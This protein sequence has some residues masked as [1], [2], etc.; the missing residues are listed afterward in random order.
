MRFLFFF[1]TFFC[2]HV[3]SAQVVV[4]GA[5]F[6]K[7][8][9]SALAG[10]GVVLLKA[11]DSTFIKGVAT[12]E[13]GKFAI[14]VT[15][16]K[17]LLK[18][19][20]LSYKTQ[21]SALNVKSENIV[22]PNILMVEDAKELKSIT[23]EKTAVRAVQKDDT[24]EYNSAAFKTNKDASTEDL[25]QKMPGITVENGTVKAKGEDVKK[26]LVDG[27]PFFGD[28]PSAALKN[29]PAE[30]VDKIQVYD[31]Q[32]DQSRFT[33]FN[34]GN[35][36]R[37]INI[38]T[39]PNMNNGVFGKIYAGYGYLNSSRYSAG[40]TV[41]WFNGNRRISVLAMS[42]NINQQNF[43]MD[44][45]MGLAGGSGGGRMRGGRMYP[46]M[47][48]NS[49]A[50]NFMV[51][52]QGGITTSQAIGINYSDQWSNKVKVTGSYFFNLT[53]NKNSSE[54]NRQY[55]A[56]GNS[57]TDYNENS[58]S[59]TR[60]MN[61]RLNFRFEYAIDSNNSLFVTPKLSIQQYN[62]KSNL[63]G[64]NSLKDGNAIS[65]LFSNYNT[66]NLGYN[67]S[68]DI[69]FQ[70]K[71]VKVGRTFSVGITGNLNNSDGDAA[72]I[73]KNN[74][75]IIQDSTELNQKTDNSTR[76]YS[77]SANFAYTEPINDLSMMQFT[78]SPSY[79]WS[80]RDKNT[81]DKD[82]LSENYDQ[83]NFQLSNNYENTYMTQKVGF[84]YRLKSKTD[85]INFS[86]GA[87][88]QYALLT[89]K[90]LFPTEGDVKKSFNNLLPNA[91]FKYN[92]SKQG[93][94]RI[95]YNASTSPPSI[96]QLQN[97]IDN[98]NP[99]LISTGNPNLKQNYQHSV[100]VRFNNTNPNNMRM[101]FGYTSFS[102]TQNYIGNSTIIALRDTLL[103]N[104]VVLNAG[105]QL[106]KPVNLSN[107]L[108]LRSFF[109]YGLPVKAI[110]SN[111]NFHAGVT[112]SRT[113]SLINGIANI[114]NTMSAMGGFVLGSNISEKIDFTIR[115][116]GNYNVVKNSL[117][118]QQNNNYYSHNANASFN[119]NFW[120][121]FVFNTSLDNTVYAGVSQGFNQN[122]FLWNAALAYKFLKDRSLEIK[123]SVFDILGQNSSV[124]R[125]VN[126]T[127]LEDVRTQVLQRYYLITITYNLKYFKK[128]KPM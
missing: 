95:N 122:F 21:L 82:T 30:A 99:L 79:T 38:I 25:I 127:Y 101:F 5:I 105:S 7:G 49:P 6:D 117:R 59:T 26:V 19:T 67:S 121:G 115:Y 22:L 109:G 4:S 53:D 41:N 69:L 118:Q 48:R 64:V 103:Q 86:I 123:G 57:T 107:S 47:L 124:S 8:D 87:E 104:N 72:L 42:N 18:Y 36:Q 46:G 78:Y 9:N 74:F 17:Y 2:A 88:M 3:L 113:P 93:N 31:Q 40:A 71:F 96:S 55:F 77:G 75:S 54:T 70:H 63:Y 94:I 13:N 23:I 112:Y 28:D 68:L 14:S 10:V 125:N 81:F 111:L 39:K 126:E 97:V 120:K 56:R 24:T 73:S 1:I 33:G 91:T 108:S 100:S 27:K 12:D 102:F 85:K 84:D 50:G 34:D 92:F 43:S 65:S 20:Y 80:K 76:S 29:L 58:A 16:G 83:R 90:Q 116:M 89:G 114:S 60:N 98:S 51:G 62:Q 35:D 106:T 37:T 52:Q 44:D 128:A 61:H 66:K 110:K 11:K 119:W 45:L 15:A 32:S